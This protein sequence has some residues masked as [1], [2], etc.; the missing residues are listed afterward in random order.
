M[1]LPRPRREFWARYISFILS[2]LSD[3]E[4]ARCYT[5]LARECFMRQMPVLVDLDP[6][7][8]ETFPCCGVRNAAHEGRCNKNRWLKA[9]FQK[10]LPAKVL[11]TPDKRQCGYIE[12][13]PGEYAW[14]GVDA[15]DY[16]F[17][18]CVWTFYKQN[19]NR[20]LGTLMV[21]SSLEDAAKAGM[22][23]VA[24]VAREQPWLAGPSL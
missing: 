16:M 13:L 17:I 6:A 2:V 18:H 22:H 15:R 9:Q 14:R 11:L 5:G 12:S 4:A 10:G 20:G 21:Q 19:Q 8:I 3:Q 1:A 7:N 23:G 24:V